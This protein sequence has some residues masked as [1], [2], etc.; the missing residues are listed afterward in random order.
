MSK[1]KEDFPEPDK[2][3]ITTNLSLGIDTSMFFRL[4]CL[5][6]FI[7]MVFFESNYSE[8]VKNYK[9]LIQKNLNLHIYSQTLSN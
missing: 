8:C 7:S 2:P 1:A 9:N 6:P 3:V 4:C 5:A